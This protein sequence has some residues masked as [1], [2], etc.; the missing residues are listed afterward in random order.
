M[1]K[2][3][4]GL[5]RSPLKRQRELVIILLRLKKE[6]DTLVI[7]NARTTVTVEAAC[8][9]HNLGIVTYGEGTLSLR[10]RDNAHRWLASFD[11]E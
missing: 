7:D 6:T 3:L 1:N 8:G 9:L 11:D 4:N 5:T 2:E 10:S